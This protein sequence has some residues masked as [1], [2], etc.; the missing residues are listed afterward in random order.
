MSAYPSHGVL[1][2][3]TRIPL[4]GESLLNVLKSL[5]FQN[6]TSPARRS[7]P[8]EGFFPLRPPAERFPHILSEKSPYPFCE[9]PFSR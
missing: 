2:S 8:R 6:T 9:T 1:L 5:P 4:I 3:Q 7:A